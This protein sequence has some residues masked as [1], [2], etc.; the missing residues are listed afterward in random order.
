MTD[1]CDYHIDVP[2]IGECFICKNPI[3]KD[4]RVHIFF[5]KTGVICK[6]CDKI[7]TIRLIIRNFLLTTPMA[8]GFGI[9]Y[10]III[11]F[12][13]LFFGVAIT[14][15]WILFYGIFISKYNKWWNNINYKK[16]SSV[17]KNDVCEFHTQRPAVNTCRICKKKVCKDCLS[18]QKLCYECY[19][20]KLVKKFSIKIIVLIGFG[21]FIVLL[22]I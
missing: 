20:N 22:S 12:Y 18:P 9:A 21:G 2:S 8:I 17:V 13:W 19:I 4:C 1:N 7:W 14:L 5:S 15:V 10:S 11:N 6:K 3:C 16:G